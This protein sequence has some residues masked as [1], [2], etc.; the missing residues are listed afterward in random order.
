M[1]PYILIYIVSF[2]FIGLG[3]YFESK[4]KYLSILFIMVSLVSLATFAG[5]S[6]IDV[7]VDKLTYANKV[8]YE[9]SHINLFTTFIDMNSEIEIGY[10]IFN[11]VVALFVNS[12]QW[13]YF[14]YTLVV[15]YLFYLC[16]RLY[17]DYMNISFVWLIFLITLYPLLLCLFRQGVAIALVSLAISLQI[18]KKRKIA[19]AILILLAIS[20]HSSGVIGILFF[21]IVYLLNKE[22]FNLKKQCILLIIIIII[23]VQTSTI[24]PA[25]TSLG[26][27]STKYNDYANGFL[28]VEGTVGIGVSAIFLL[29]GLFY[30]KDIKRDKVFSIVYFF[31]IVNTFI[32]PLEQISAV[33]GRLG[34]YFKIFIAIYYAFMVRKTFVE[35]KINIKKIVVGFLIVIYLITANNSFVLGL[36]NQADMGTFGIF[37][38]ESNIFDNLVS[39]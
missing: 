29:I 37:P 2:S 19:P 24:L 18:I 20:F 17:K 11:W 36:R 15:S 27:L 34:L 28:G 32:Y 23:M 16:I 21:G 4:N 25:L 3:G 7:G 38:Y 33:L 13:Y 22:Q 26:L 31:S 8:F 30:I 35:N 14:I 12:I 5:I 9:A 6:D 10:L 1:F 39:R